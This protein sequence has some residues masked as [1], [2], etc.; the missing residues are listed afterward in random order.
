[1]LTLRGTPE[2]EI[3]EWALRAGAALCREETTG[4]W[5]AMVYLP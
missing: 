5:Q 4:Q 2:S 3:I 1:V